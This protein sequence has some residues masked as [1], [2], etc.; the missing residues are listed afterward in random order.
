MPGSIPLLPCFL[1]FN[2]SYAI[3]AFIYANILHIPLAEN[4]E[5]TNSF[6]MTSK[7]F[8]AFLI[9]LAITIVFTLINVQI[10]KKLGKPS[11]DLPVIKDSLLL[12][13]T[14]MPIGFVFTTAAVEQNTNLMINL[15]KELKQNA[16]KEGELWL[17]NTMY[18]FHSCALI[19]NIVLFF[20]VLTWQE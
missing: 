14:G 11:S 19:T 7:L 5:E 15:G 17:P 1:I 16:K 13:L 6:A 8:T 12:A 2:S 9:I 20:V 18:F 3:A 10:Y 4:A